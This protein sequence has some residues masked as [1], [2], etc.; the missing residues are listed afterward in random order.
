MTRE[1]LHNT[2][3]DALSGPIPDIDLNEATNL[4]RDAVEQWITRHPV[5]GPNLRGPALVYHWTEN[6]TTLIDL[7]A[8]TN[9]RE[10]AICTALMM[11]AAHHIR[12]RHNLT[13]R[14]PK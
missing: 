14:D 11:E 5:H 13:T 4:V 3:R 1:S 6:T 10:A 12:D 8:P 2:I 9:R 7:A